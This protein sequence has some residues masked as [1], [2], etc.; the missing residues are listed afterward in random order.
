MEPGA[1][2]EA[3]VR[4]ANATLADHQKI[5]AAAVWPSGELP[6]TEGTRK[7]KRRELRGFGPPP[8]RRL[9]G[10]R[11]HAEL[12]GLLAGLG[13]HV[14]VCTGANP[15]RHGSLLAD[16]GLPAAVFPVAGEPTAELARTAAA[17][18]REHGAD[19]IA[20]IG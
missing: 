2:V 7:L 15:A 14:L 17:A 13:S 16:L 10:D 1:D 3:I 20:A 9:A 8:D 12:D 6:R 18:A 19:V 11:P 4:A 5:R